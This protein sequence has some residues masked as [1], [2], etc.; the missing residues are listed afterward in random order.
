MSPIPGF[1]VT[2]NVTKKDR[3]RR[4]L[5]LT[6]VWIDT[7]FFQTAVFSTLVRLSNL[8]IYPQ[9]FKFQLGSTPHHAATLRMPRRQDMDLVLS[10]KPL[11]HEQF[12]AFSANMNDCPDKLLIR[13]TFADDATTVA[14]AAAQPPPH[15]IPM[16]SYPLQGTLEGAGEDGTARSAK[17]QR[18]R[19]WRFKS[20][21]TRAGEKERREVRQGQH[22]MNVMGYEPRPT[23]RR[24]ATRFA[25]TRSVAGRGAP[26][27][28]PDPVGAISRHPSRHTFR[29]PQAGG[30]GG[31]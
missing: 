27:V 28:P 3:L 19:A 12:D 5:I 31:G 2:K 18:M 1:P 22:V 14:A 17:M 4:L 15:R 11:T 24:S 23:R 21:C 13:S 8:K 9:S 20:H 7:L 25:P 16:P 10:M 6:F 26:P 29:R 30:D